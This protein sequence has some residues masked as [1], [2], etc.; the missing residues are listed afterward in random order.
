MGKEGLNTAYCFLAIENMPLMIKT[1]NLQFCLSFEQILLLNCSIKNFF[2]FLPLQ[3][4]RSC[5]KI[6]LTFLIVFWTIFWELLLWKL[7]PGNFVFFLKISL[8]LNV[9][10][11]FYMFLNIDFAN[12][13]RELLG[14]RMRNFQGGIFIWTRT[15]REIFKSASVYL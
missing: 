10:Y 3:L 7:S 12:L 1:G 15:Y 14:L 6:R 11:C 9:F 2:F 8:L 13:T 5:R 4:L